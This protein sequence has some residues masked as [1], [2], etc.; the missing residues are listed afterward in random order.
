MGIKKIVLLKMYILEFF[1]CVWFIN[2]C[3]FHF[4]LSVSCRQWEK[5]SRYD[6]NNKWFFQFT[7]IEFDLFMIKFYLR[8]QI[9]VSRSCYINHNIV[10]IF[11][12]RV[13]ESQWEVLLMTKKLIYKRNFWVEQA[14]LAEV[15]YNYAVHIQRS[16]A[17]SK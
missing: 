16:T 4:L 2:K 9:K 7:E 8:E 1:L 6:R 13:V 15:I 10:T 11:M 5:C 3:F 17:V 14:P 12:V